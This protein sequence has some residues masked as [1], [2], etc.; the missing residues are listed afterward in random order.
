LAKPLL[1][2]GVFEK[3]RLLPSRRAVWA[4]KR[5]YRFYWLSFSFSPPPAA[6]LAGSTP[7]Q[8]GKAV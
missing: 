4:A 7:L 3:R 5:F 1:L 2:A 8:Y 6:W